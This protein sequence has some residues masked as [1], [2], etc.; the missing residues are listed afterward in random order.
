MSVVSWGAP[1]LKFLKL[2][3][4]TAPSESDW[5][6]ASVV[7]IS[8][9]V[10]LEGATTLETSDGDTKEVKNEKG[11]VV[12]SKQMPS[13]YSLSASIIKKKGENI[14]KEKFAPVNG[15]V[16]GNWAMRLIAEDSETW[17]FTFNKCTLSVAKSWSAEQGML[18]VLT[19]KGI[20][21]DTES[22][23]ICEEYSSAD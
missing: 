17:G 16:S 5:A 15:V 20:E 14:V 23:E 2:S 9:D 10:L 7:T 11:N 1:T 3:G 19:V 22:K 6:G 12:D 21:P 8:G 4:N 13:S 18:D